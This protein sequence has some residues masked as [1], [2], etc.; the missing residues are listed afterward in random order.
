[1]SINDLKV[2][3]KIKYNDGEFVME[4]LWI[5]EFNFVYRNKNGAEQLTSL[6]NLHHY[7]PVEDTG[8]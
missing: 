2:G 7:T 1:M 3:M 5:G 8:N 4:I 6:W